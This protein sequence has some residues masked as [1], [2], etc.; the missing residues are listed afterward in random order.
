MAAGAGAEGKAQ[1]RG[2]VRDWRAT[3][4]AGGRA[5]R[6][7]LL[8]ATVASRSRIGLTWSGGG[9][10]SRRGKGIDE[11]ELYRIGWP[12]ACTVCVPNAQPAVLLEACF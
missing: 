7:A 11:R 12:N 10:G 8:A 5:G 9:L 6:G 3:A 2:G 4:K 1:L